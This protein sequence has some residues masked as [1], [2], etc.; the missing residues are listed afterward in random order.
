MKTNQTFNPM[1]NT[2]WSAAA[3]DN[4]QTTL[5]LLLLAN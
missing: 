2:N 4:S 1:T 5:L 3:F